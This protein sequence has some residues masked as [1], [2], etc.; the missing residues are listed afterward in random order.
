MGYL[1]QGHLSLLEWG[2][3]EAHRLVASIF[4]NP[5][6]FG[7][8]EDLARY[9]RDL[10]RDSTLCEKA[11]VDALF[12]PEAAEMY[13]EGYQTWVEVEH[14]S[15]GLCG[16]ARPGHFR[17]VA[18]VVLKLLNIVRPNLAVFGLK[19]Y[20]QYLVV[21]R[22]AADLDL[23]VEIVGRPVV[24]E[25]DGLA[26]SSR[27]AYLSPEERRSALVLSEALGE[28]RRLVTAGERDA[29]ALAARL[30]A[31]VAARQG[32]RLDYLELRHPDT[33]EEVES[34]GGPTLL[35]LAAWVGKT[36]LIDNALLLEAGEA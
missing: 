17:G 23:D 15:R 29:L 3:R 22:L 28:A 30:K 34:L 26:M 12:V 18:T 9:P 25:A 36:R 4:V 33:L 27:N 14:L 35:A 11:G 5:A 32:V 10:V 6:Q 2:R 7:P 21:K 31:M 8:Q 24:R 13:P 1:H 16:A 20:Q 19:D